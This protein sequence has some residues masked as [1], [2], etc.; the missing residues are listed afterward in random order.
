V[1]NAAPRNGETSPGLAISNHVVKLLSD[2]TGRG[3]TKAR[4]HFSNNLVTVVVEDL[5]T[6]GERSLVRDGK[7]ELVLDMRRA[8]QQ[9]MATAL[10]EGVEEVVDRKVVAFLSANTVDPDF[11]IESFIL[12]PVNGAERPA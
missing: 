4:T 5:L 3:P 2:Y 1:S 8:Y 12:A 6:K 10:T 7:A 9:T 11:A